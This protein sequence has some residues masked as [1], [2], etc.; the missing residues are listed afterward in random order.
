MH[1][2]TP[3]ELGLRGAKVDIFLVHLTQSRELHCGCKQRQNPSVTQGKRDGALPLQV[4]WLYSPG[5]ED[6]LSLLGGMPCL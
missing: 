6:D 3:K 5:Q 4:P 2:L 1:P